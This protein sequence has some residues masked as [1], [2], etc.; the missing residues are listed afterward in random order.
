[1]N[2]ES[3]MSKL[4][5]L[6]QKY[7]SLCHAMQSGVAMEMN[8]RDNPTTPKHLRVGVNSAMCDNAAMARLLMT[9]GII[10]EEE[11]FE[12]LCTVMQEEVERYEKDLQE[13]AGVNT[14]ITLK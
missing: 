5:D 6:K 8:Y 14:K 4:D 1:M 13:M 9:K 10:T 2:K 12:S 3:L 11:Y 7:H